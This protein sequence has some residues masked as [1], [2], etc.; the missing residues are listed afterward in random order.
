MSE[1]QNKFNWQDDRA[2]DDAYYISDTLNNYMDEFK[3]LGAINGIGIWVYEDKTYTYVAHYFY[4]DTAKSDFR[5]S[6]N[7]YRIEKDEQ[8]RGLNYPDQVDPADEDHIYFNADS[9]EKPK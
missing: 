1:L 3:E 6:A 5:H 8:V 9:G 2:T 4:D 7:L